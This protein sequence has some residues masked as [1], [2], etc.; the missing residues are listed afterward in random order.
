VRDHA[1]ML[2][3]L[4]RG[5]PIRFGRGLDDLPA[6]VLG[7][8]AGALVGEL[9]AGALMNALRVAV[10]GLLRE[11]A[12]IVPASEKVAPDVRGLLVHPD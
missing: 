9:S 1:L 11:S 8:F 7:A 2:A 10:D 12:Q 6:D 5:L 4:R 3:C